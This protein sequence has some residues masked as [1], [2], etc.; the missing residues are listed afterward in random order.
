MKWNAIVN[1]YDMWKETLICFN[2]NVISFLNML[3]N[4]ETHDDDKKKI[5]FTSA[6]FLFIY[7]IFRVDLNDF[8]LLA[9]R[10]VH[11]SQSNIDSTAKRSRGNW[12]SQIISVMFSSSFIIYLYTLFSVDS[13]SAKVSLCCCS[14]TR[15]LIIFLFG[16]KWAKSIGIFGWKL[17]YN[18]LDPTS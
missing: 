5:H 14:L 18:S 6:L 17:E 7:F 11:E 10:V 1:R 9:P 8:P 4:V 16:E 2:L 12:P 3:H 13:V 15:C